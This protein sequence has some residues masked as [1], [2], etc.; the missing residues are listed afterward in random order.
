MART[1]WLF[2]IV[3]LNKDYDVSLRTKLKTFAAPPRI[4][5]EG[6]KLRQE[7]SP[8]GLRK[9]LLLQTN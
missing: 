6:H 1:T 4:I 9:K 7:M 5:I 2:P 3:G 8:A